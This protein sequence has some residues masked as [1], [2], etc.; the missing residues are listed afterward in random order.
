[1][2]AYTAADVK[3]LREATAAGM[4]DC[5]KALD[6]AAKAAGQ[7]DETPAKPEKSMPEF[8]MSG[9][10]NGIEGTMA[11]IRQS[12]AGTF[13]ATAAWG[14]GSAGNAEERTAAATEAV[15]RNTA[16][17]NKKLDNVMVFG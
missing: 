8:D 6:E 1:M 2:A 14:M 7:A 12:I 15:A 4:L 10:M 5:K 13:S 17:T 3:R 11:T 16:A 9:L